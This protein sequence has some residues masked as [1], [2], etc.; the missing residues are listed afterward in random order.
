M[1]RITYILLFVSLLQPIALKA[2]TP[3]D[4]FAPE[5]SRPMLE[6]DA[7]YEEIVKEN[8]HADTILCAAVIDFQS[9]S[10][11]LVSLADGTLL[12]SAPLTD[13][14]QK[15]LSV[16]PLVDKNIA[17]AP[18]LYCGGNP[19]R[20]VDPDG[21]DDF[22]V[23]WNQEEKKVSIKQIENNNYDQFHIIDADGNRIA[24]SNQYEY[25]TITKLRKGKWAESSLVLFD[26][27]GDNNAAN[28]FEFLGT[29]FTKK[30]GL[31]LEWSRVMV[32]SANS[33][34]NILGT[35]MKEDASGVGHYILFHGYT[36]LGV[37]HNHPG[38][39]GPSGEDIDNAIIYH[40][41]F[42]GAVLRVFTGGRYIPY[43]ENT[44]KPAV[45]GE[46][47]PEVIITP[48]K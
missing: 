20:F 19:I 37:D 11:Y 2:Q 9:Q 45:I 29:N 6:T 21:R 23:Y 43:N 30:K 39:S 16:D 33:G 17:T 32:G 44:P 18:Y 25:G 13:E 27:N 5:T 42:P 10:L 4:S 47:L 31:P 22:E 35:S 46:E 48:F 3:Y 24:S 8:R 15:W 40:T 38:G 7:L 1:K 26:V 14:V 41:P 12:A 28:L 36:I 34:R